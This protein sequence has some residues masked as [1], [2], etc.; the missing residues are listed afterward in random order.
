MNLRRKT[1]FLIGI[2]FLCLIVFLYSISTFIIVDGFIKVEQRD[3]EK[4]VN[5]VLGAI[6]DDIG[7]L[8]T[9]NRDWAQWDDTYEF[10]RDVNPEYIKAV[11]GDESL[12][13]LRLNLVI[14]VN[15][16]GEMVFARG[17]DVQEKK[18]L[19]IPEG[20]K[21]LIN[22]DSRLLNHNEPQSSYSGIVLLPE[23][24]LI[25]TSY[26]I[27]N[28]DGEGPVRGT[29]I[30]GRY[31]DEVEL[32]RL[33]S[34]TQMSLTSYR[35]DNKGLP[36]DFKAAL[37]LFSL[38]K[39][40]IV[41]PL[42]GDVAGYTVLNDIN[43]DPALLLRV[44]LPREIYN[45]GI[46]SINYFL[47]SLIF[48]SLIFSSISI[49]LIEEEVLS[50]ILRLN[51]DVTRIK[52]SKNPSKHVIV[53]GKD[54]ISYLSNSIND[55]LEGLEHSQAEQKKSQ[56]E[57]KRNR[58]HL[59]EIVES[60]TVQL[61][62]SIQEKE[63]LLR[64]IHHRVKNNMQIVSSLL[65]L[66]SQ[67][68]EDKKYRDIF[69]DSQNRIQAMALIHQKLYQ[70]E[71]IAQINFKEYIDGIVSNIFESYG[72]K[73]NIIFD[74]NIENIHIKIDY[75]VPC[76]LIINELVTNSFKY[77]FPD[78]RQ[79]K[80]KISVKSNDNDMIQISIS[81]NGIGIPKDMDIRN[82]KSLG[83]KLITGLA[84]NQLHGEIILKRERGTEFQINFRQAK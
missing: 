58:D 17:F 40:I 55:M 31:L 69:I 74:I 67:N 38:D 53:E 71:S 60:R 78:G 46:I 21:K 57:L 23:G 12:A 54:E 14:Y 50:R 51:K 8:E 61:N 30:F 79:G 15:S 10:I 20:L 63:V 73:S 64:E 66:Q 52:N 2:T 27:L 65:K 6:S 34:I 84:E 70:S 18:E 1:L 44:D 45:Q 42:N 24:N 47:I 32:M 81:D 49:W 41:R 77:A 83:L 59:E 56:D 82:T 35:L 43:G 28:S 68:I 26:A 33:A 80:I 13:G 3:V 62:N 72:Q 48:V 11:L 76:G 5:R 4:N 29:L 39:K 25:I 36:A 19:P 75:A 9:M 16:T 22:K 37:P 7:N